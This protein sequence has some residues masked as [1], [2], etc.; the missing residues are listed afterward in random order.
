MTYISLLW[1]SFYGK[2]M[3]VGTSRGNDRAG[4]AFQLA[5]DLAN[6]STWSEQTLIDAGNFIDIQHGNGKCLRFSTLKLEDAAGRAHHHHHH[7]HHLS[8]SLALS[9]P[10]RSPSLL[11]VDV[12]ARVRNFVRHNAFKG[13]ERN[14]TTPIPGMFA[15]SHYSNGTCGSAIWWLS[16]KNS[17]KHRVNSCTECG[18]PDCSPENLHNVPAATMDATPE[19]PSFDC[20]WIGGG[21]FGVGDYIHPSLID[22]SSTDPNFNTVGET[23]SLFFV[24]DDCKQRLYQDGQESCTPWDNDGILHRDVI[25]VPVKFSK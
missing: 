19:G 10:P 16:P 8:L 6:P 15:R 21:A 1:S 25:K 3:A 4:V 2:Y 9:R 18:I 17:S 12:L 11:A 5:D 22:E 24:T 13:T 14:A 7:H 23:A 20:H